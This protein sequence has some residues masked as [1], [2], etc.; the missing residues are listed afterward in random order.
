MSWIVEYKNLQHNDMEKSKKSFGFRADEKLAEIILNESKKTK[1]SA[2]AFIRAIL[3][4]VL[5][6]DPQ[7]EG[8]AEWAPSFLP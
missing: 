1:R 7:D 3:E 2:S 4:M 8:F 5:L 6:P